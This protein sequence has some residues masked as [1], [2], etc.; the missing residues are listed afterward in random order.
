MRQDAWAT[1][2][3]W[4]WFRRAQWIGGFRKAKRKGCEPFARALEGRRLVLGS[5]C[6][7]GLNAAT[8]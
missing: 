4:E 2:Y 6:G 7:L 3:R 1:F 8:K 5:S